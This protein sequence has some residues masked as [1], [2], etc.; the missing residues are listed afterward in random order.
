MES[1][2]EH[3]LGGDGATL[4]YEG[5]FSQAAWGCTRALFDIQIFILV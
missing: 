2:H 5:E 4:G 3:A 1:E